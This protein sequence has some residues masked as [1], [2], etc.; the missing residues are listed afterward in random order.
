[1]LIE[2]GAGSMGVDTLSL[3]YGLSGDFITHYTWLP[4]GKIGIENLK[5]L[6]DVPEAGATIVIGAPK[7]AGGTGGPARI[8]ALV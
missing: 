7:F 3:D 8:F 5:A 4:A 6:S 1:M 2:A